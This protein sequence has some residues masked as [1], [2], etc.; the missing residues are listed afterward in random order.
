MSGSVCELPARSTGPART[1]GSVRRAISTLADGRPAVLVGADGAGSL[2]LAA[3]RAATDQL[4]FLI[5]HG[6]GIVF[7]ALSEQVCERLWLPPMT[8]FGRRGPASAQR[9]AVDAACGISTGISAADRA[10]TVRL[11]ADPDSTPDDFSRPG[12]VI[13][14]QAR[15]GAWGLTEAAVELT[16]V[17][18]PPGAVTCA[19]VS[20]HDSCEIA[21]AAELAEFASAHRLELVTTD[22]V[23]HYLGRRDSTA[24]SA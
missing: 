15:D 3:D 1:S 16:G 12:H 5:R 23:A 17:A 11:L 10:R 14:L 4:A 7:V 24:R 21:D 20:R 18:G 22:A 19:V 9:V 2:V 13:P 6:S 8:P